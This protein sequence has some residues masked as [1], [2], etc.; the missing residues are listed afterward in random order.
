MVSPFLVGF[1]F[2]ML[3]SSP[4]TKSLP[5]LRISSGENMMPLSPFQVLFSI[6]TYFP[7]AD[8][9]TNLALLPV[10]MQLSSELFWERSYF[11]ASSKTLA[12]S[13][14]VFLGELSIGIVSSCGQFTIGSI[15]RSI[16][17]IASGLWHSSSKTVL[18]VTTKSA[19]VG[20][21]LQDHMRPLAVSN[22]ASD[23]FSRRSKSRFS[24]T[25]NTATVFIVASVRHTRRQ[26]QRTRIPDNTARPHAM[27]TTTLAGL[28]FS[29]SYRCLRDPIDAIVFI[30]KYFIF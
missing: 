10:S 2:W 27:D 26:P 25:Y 20:I 15:L 18:E 17:Q 1:K 5:P 8:F 22:S 16:F 3:Y 4:S 11:L 29:G 6:Y 12:S 7:D 30:I 23:A 24:L 13:S 28:N 19:Y 9:F 14:T 21:V